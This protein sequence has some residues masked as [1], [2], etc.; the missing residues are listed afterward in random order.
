MTKVKTIDLPPLPA[1]F[2][3]LITA[4]DQYYGVETK[5]VKKK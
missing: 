4:M 3:H 1:H 5:F 2:P